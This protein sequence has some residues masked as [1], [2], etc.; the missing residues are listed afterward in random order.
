[1]NA[2]EAAE[3]YGLQ[4][5]GARPGLWTYL[6]QTWARRDFAYTLAK[7]RIHARNQANRLGVVWEI[8][9]PTLNAVMYGVIFGLLQ[10]D[11][12]GHD[13]PAFVVIGVFLFEFF[14][15]SMTQGA[16]A[17]TGNRS[18]VQSLNFPRLTLPFS[19]MLQQLMTLAPMILVMFIYVLIL[20]HQP[21]W[22]WLLIVP[23]IFLYTLF[24]FGV[25]LICARLTVHLNDLT[26]LLPLL[27]R[28]LFY[29]S[30]V[31][32]SVSSILSAWPWMITVYDF[33]PIYQVLQLARGFILGGTNEYDP[34]YWGW[35]ALW[36]SVVFIVGLIFFWRAEERY[37]REH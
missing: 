11:K 28:I 30:G 3:Q 33:H 7:S 25:A 24:N 4:K 1:M 32:F 23:L 29:T 35:L 21:T 31:L 16:R 34:S 20:G 36:S 37:G 27:T 6:K 13:Y 17:I 26:Q 19:M 15:H 14:S 2:A 18:L 22:M 12:R 9:K 5:V 10:G 8:I